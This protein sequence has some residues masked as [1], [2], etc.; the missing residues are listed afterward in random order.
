MAHHYLSLSP[1]ALSSCA[2]I[3]IENAWGLK[4][5]HR[6]AAIRATGRFVK[7]QPERLRALE[8][9]GFQWQLR[10]G[11]ASSTSDGLDGVT[12]DQIYTALATYRQFQSQTSTAGNPLSVP[13]TFIVPNSPQWPE[14]TR[15]LPLG[16]LLPLVRSKAFLKANPEAKERLEALDVELDGKTAMNDARFQKVYEALKRYREIHGDL[17]VPQPFVVPS[18]SNDWAE[19]L[20]GL[21]LGARVN[22]IRSQGTFVGNNPDRKKLLDDLGFVWSPPPSTDR[23]KK[24]G[25]RSKAELENERMEFGN[26]QAAGDDDDLDFN[27]MDGEE[28]E[29]EEVDDDNQEDDGEDENASSSLETWFGQSFDFGS[30]N[31]LSGGS[32]PQAPPTWGLQQGGAPKLAGDMSSNDDTNKVVDEFLEPQ[33]LA[34]SLKAAFDRAVEVGVIEPIR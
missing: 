3:R 21:R 6:V 9:L 27:S 22:A 13:P 31:N 25:R 33:S 2:F 15:G 24:R 16:K 34:D 11:G 7:D 4:L 32:P 1:F 26:K 19:D 17:L 14:S 28:D 10:S 18:K 8:K 20:W 23:G 5:G 12:L 29:E 30:S